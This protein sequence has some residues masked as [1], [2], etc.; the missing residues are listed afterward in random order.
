MEDT[1]SRIESG[2]KQLWVA[3]SREDEELVDLHLQQFQRDLL[4]EEIYLSIWDERLLA[5]ALHLLR[6][7]CGEEL[8]DERVEKLNRHLSIVRVV[9]NRLYAILDHKVGIDDLL[10]LRLDKWPQLSEAIGCGF[11]DAAKE[12]LQEARGIGSTDQRLENFVAIYFQ[13]L[14][15]NGLGE[16]VDILGPSIRQALAGYRHAL[17]KTVYGLFVT[18]GM[19]EVHG[20]KIRRVASGSG[21]IHHVSPVHPDMDKAANGAMACVTRLHPSIKQWDFQWDIGRDDVAF[22]G[23]SI[24]LALTLG[25]LAELER[26]NID[27]YTAFT[28]YVEW[29]T[30]KVT[31]IEQLDKKLTA[32]K[33]LGIRRVFIPRENASELDGEGIEIIAVGSVEEAKEWLQT[34]TYAQADTPLE[35][36]AS[37]R[38][39]ELEIEL[40]TKGIHKVGQVQHFQYYKRVVFSDYQGRIFVDVF[41]GKEGLKRVI[42]KNCTPLQQVVEEACDKVFGAVPSKDSEAKPRFEKLDVANPADRKRVEDYI[43]GRDDAIRESMQHCDYRARI[44]R[45]H[46]T[47]FV[48]QYSKGTL[49]IQGSPGPLLEEIWRDVRAILGVPDIDSGNDGQKIHR[50][51]Q[52]AAVEAVQLGQ[53]WIGTDESGKGDYYGPLVGA[54]VLV[55]EQTATLLEELG[56][57]DSKKLSDSRV[58]KLAAQIRQVCGKRATVVVIPPERYNALYEQFRAESKNLNTLLA[59]VHTRALEDILSE[60]PQKRITVLVDKFADES[61]IQSKL[62]EK[63]RQT[64]LNLVQLPKAEANIAVAAAS[65]LARAQFLRWLER[66]SRQHGVDLPKGASDPRIVQVG[67]QIVA[68]SGEDGL[69]KVAKLHF[70]TTKKIFT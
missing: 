1:V 68:R 40:R 69:A 13:Y 60:F 67:K 32:A 14:E 5:Q 65:V 34:R 64:D 20:L 55:D 47:V 44:A 23:T 25:I 50:Q 59:W 63:G 52:I 30:G 51:S 15:K 31:R 49:M 12:A 29:D 45:S 24:G 70:R 39:R 4:N 66:L 3:L 37:I 36:L 28:G 54:A 22:T 43:F 10:I 48:H 8:R 41:H 56:V 61:Y 35:R 2:I 9:H 21:Q 57:K 16:T 27:A 53:Q 18:R 26:L 38:I 62:L 7:C 11:D 42:Q 46:Q 17:S 33:D 6:L 58:H 19:G